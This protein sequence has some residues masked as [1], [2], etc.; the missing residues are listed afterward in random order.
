M[1]FLRAWLAPLLLAGLGA[2]QRDEHG[3]ADELAFAR[4][5]APLY[6]DLAEDFLAR[7]AAE[8]LD[9]SQRARVALARAQVLA[10]AAEAEARA[11][12]RAA[13]L[14][15]AL[16][17][18]RSCFT[19]ALE[20]RAA[21]ELVNACARAFEPLRAAGG[22]PGLEAGL[23]GVLEGAL[24]LGPASAADAPGTG[25]ER[26]RTDLERA[27]AL[28]A[29]ARAGGAAERAGEGR[30]VLERIARE[31]GES[32]GPGLSARLELAAAELARGAPAEAAAAAER[33]FALALPP[34]APETPAPNV[35][36]LQVASLALPL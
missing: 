14:G 29:L 10:A 15:R 25:P 35:E 21:L 13:L 3:L 12:E 18:A 6:L 5:L 2:A 32:S 28:F 36:E 33:V 8:P 20:P 24:R 27:R 1:S 26:W 19:G 31:A 22:E 17:A 34:R 4:A 7:L 16:E 30:A 9:E 11:A 23:R